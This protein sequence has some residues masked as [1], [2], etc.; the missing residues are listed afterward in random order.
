MTARELDAATSTYSHFRSQDG[1]TCSGYWSTWRV[2]MILNVMGSISSTVPRYPFGTYTRA[3]T[4][5]TAGLNFPIPVAA[6]TFGPVSPVADGV[7]T[8]ALGRGTVG[9]AAAAPAPRPAGSTGRCDEAYAR[10]PAM[11]AVRAIRTSTTTGNGTR[12]RG[13]PMAAS[14]RLPSRP[15]L[16]THEERAHGL[17]AGA[18]GLPERR[19]VQP[20]LDRPKDRVMAD[21]D[22]GT[23][24]RGHDRSGNDRGDVSAAARAAAPGI[25]GALVPGQEQHAALADRPEER[26][27]QPLE[28]PIA[29]RDAAVVGVVA[30]VGRDPGELRKAPPSEVT[31]ELRQRHDLRAA[32]GVVHDV[33]EVQ[34][35]VVLLGVQ[36]RR[37]SGEARRGHALHV[38]L[39]RD[40]GML[41]LVHEI[42]AGDMT[43]GAVRCDAEGRATDQREVVGQR[44]VGDGEGVGREPGLP[45]Q[46]VDEG[47]PL[48]ADHCAVLLV[49][50]DHHDDVR[51]EDPGARSRARAGGLRPRRLGCRSRGRAA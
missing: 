1:V 33:V 42:G 51:E 2:R 50:H 11:P 17:G 21:R 27:H 6:Y 39:P 5:A 49:L 4:P 44:R 48:V 29:G 12:G 41:E 46:P 16:E 10:I 13:S 38:G 45:R 34:E 47:R 35:R 19:Q 3:G 25:R 20:R 7:G 31:G 32:R 22:A 23:E 24:P 26:R 36:A 43:V 9:E 37:R 30:E 8:V 40:P 14:Y 15:G 18:P 28:K